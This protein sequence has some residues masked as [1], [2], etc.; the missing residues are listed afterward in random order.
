MISTSLSPDGHMRYH[1]SPFYLDMA[2][3]IWV[4]R[5]YRLDPQSARVAL[6][7]G[8]ILTI[9]RDRAEARR[10]LKRAS[11]DPEDVEFASEAKRELGAF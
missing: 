8:L 4:R 6:R 10:F 1:V 9:K 3:F 2:H 7:I 11:E 5:A